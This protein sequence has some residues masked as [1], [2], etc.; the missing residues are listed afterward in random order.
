MNSADE[1]LAT[2]PKFRL[3]HLDTEKP[4]PATRELSMLA[5][6][7]LP[8]ALNILAQIDSEAINKVAA[9]VEKIL[10]LREAI[11]SVWQKGHKV[12]LCGCGA[13]GRLSLA[14]EYLYREK[15][16]NEN[17]IA[18]MAGGDVALVHSLEGF[19]DFPEHGARHLLQLGFQNGDLLI[20]CTEGG[21][22]PYVIGATEEAARVS[23]QNPYFLYCN[24]DEIL[25]KHVD[26]SR[27]VIENKRIEKI[28]LAVG[29]MALAGSTRMQASSVLQLAVGIALL[30]DAARPEI[31]QFLKE[32]QQYLKTEAS[33]FLPKFIERESAEYKSERFVF[34]W[35]RNYPITVFTD[36]TE[37]APTFSLTPFSHRKA[38][39]LLKLK[40]SL[41]Y[42]ALPDAKNAN[43]AWRQMLLREPISLNWREVDDRTGSEYLEAFDF[44]QNAREF[45]SWL[46]KDAEHSDFK[47]EKIADRLSWSFQD[48]QRSLQYPVGDIA[49]DLLP[50]FEHTLL[51]MF[52]NMHSTLVMGRLGRYKRNLMTWVYPT[53]G[54]LIDRATRYAQTLLHEDGVAVPYDDVVRKLFEMK[55]KVTANESIV[56]ATYEALR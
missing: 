33:E 46:T 1:F 17:V 29:P 43:E 41:C 23:S 38:E 53:N 13:T 48:L 54:K 11:R 36:T 19:E 5:N 14:L 55:A 9:Q 35:V 18:F 30:S 7:N 20:S 22:T 50:L 44:S 56:L 37:R 31:L 25:V 2:G 3:G 16:K 32:L 6:E 10:H 39:R 26:R 21:E 8:Q 15:N 34:Y 24:P 28:N 51:K 40:P 42:L 52:L 47:I 12:Y 45:R 4:H 49:A 27:R